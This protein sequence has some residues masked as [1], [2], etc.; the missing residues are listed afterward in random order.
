MRGGISERRGYVRWWSTCVGPNTESG[1]ISER[2]VG[3]RGVLY[4][5]R[6]C[7]MT[8]VVHHLHRSKM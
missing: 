1:G 5:E 8:M 7:P 4:D 2:V 3:L 6:V